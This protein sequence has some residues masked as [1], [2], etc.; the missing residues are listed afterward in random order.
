MPGTIELALA[1]VVERGVDH[2]RIPLRTHQ[3]LQVPRA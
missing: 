1:Y 2:E 3:P